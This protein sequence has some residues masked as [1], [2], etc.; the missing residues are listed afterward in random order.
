MNDF[1]LGNEISLAQRILQTA[2]Q[3]T[4]CATL[5]GLGYAA[6]LVLLFDTGTLG[7]GGSLDSHR[8]A[9]LPELL[10]ADVGRRRS[11]SGQ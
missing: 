1:G 4:G 5:L 3:D 9:G 7:A 11:G 2:L 6:V 10:P 8:S